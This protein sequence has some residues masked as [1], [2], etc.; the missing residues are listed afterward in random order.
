MKRNRREGAQF[1]PLPRIRSG[2]SS[3]EAKPT[4]TE[5]DDLQETAGHCNI[6]EEVDE[7]VPG[8]GQ[9]TME[10][11]CRRHRRPLD[12]RDEARAITDDQRCATEISTT[13]A[14]ASE[15]SEGRLMD[16]DVADRG[17]RRGEFREPGNQIDCAEQNPPNYDTT[18][19]ETLESSDPRYCSCETLV[20]WDMHSFPSCK[21][22]VHCEGRE[23][24]RF[25]SPDHLE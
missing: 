23:C 16:V 12:R 2:A 13:M 11:E 14:M 22:A 3:V 18:A 20:Y 6:L 17:G 24:G 7:L 21:Q 19:R 8:P 9:I 1:V 5:C 25:V 10:G 4:G 15:R